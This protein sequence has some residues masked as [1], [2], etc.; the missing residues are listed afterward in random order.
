MA[1]IYHIIIEKIWGERETLLNGV[2]GFYYSPAEGTIPPGMANIYHIIIEKIWERERKLQ[3]SNG[4][5]LLA[6]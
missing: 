2:T 3:W 1:N 6:S 4:I 5:L